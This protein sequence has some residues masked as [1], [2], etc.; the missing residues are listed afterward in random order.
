MISILFPVP[1]RLISGTIFPNRFLFRHE[2]LP[3][4]YFRFRRPA[5][6]SLAR[7]DF[8]LLTAIFTVDAATPNEFTVTFP[9]FE[10]LVRVVTTS[11][12]Q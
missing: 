3:V 1:L 5:S 6:E 2:S 12:A 7:V 11:A 9:R 4:Y 10:V 8:H